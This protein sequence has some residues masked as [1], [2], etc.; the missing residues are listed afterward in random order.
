M[1]VVCCLVL[2]G[3]VGGVFAQD[4]PDFTKDLKSIADRHAAVLMAQKELCDAIAVHQKKVKDFYCPVLTPPSPTPMPVPHVEPIPA[5]V[6]SPV[7]APVKPKTP[8]TGGRLQLLV[9]EGAEVVVDGVDRGSRPGGSRI[10][11]FPVDKGIDCYYVVRVISDPSHFLERKVVV[12]A[13][14]TT[15]EDMR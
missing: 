10:F 9:P 4:Q 8:A 5:P 11:E 15:V 14:V 13:G 3:L 1:R 6:K 7:P 2:L 12:K